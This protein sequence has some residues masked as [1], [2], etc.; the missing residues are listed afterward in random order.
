MSAVTGS[1]INYLTH[2]VRSREHA[3]KWRR[4]SSACMLCG[5]FK[6]Q[7]RWTVSI[8][9]RHQSRG[10]RGR[11]QKRWKLLLHDST[12]LAT[13]RGRGGRPVVVDEIQRQVTAAWRDCVKYRAPLVLFEIEEWSYE[14]IGRRWSFAP[15]P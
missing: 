2:L 6:E 13:E 12:Q 10:H 14:E 8:P 7:E 15:E 1:L 3:R 5:G 4:A 11:R 9:D